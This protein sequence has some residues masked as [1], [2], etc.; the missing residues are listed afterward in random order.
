M[1]AL[2]KSIVNDVDRGAGFAILG[3]EPKGPDTHLIGEAVIS[4]EPTIFFESIADLCIK[5]SVK[6]VVLDLHKSAEGHH[7]VRFLDLCCGNGIKVVAVDCLV[8]YQQYLAHI[9]LPSIFFD[10]NDVSVGPRVCE[11]SL[12]WDHFLLLRSGEAAIWEPGLDVLVLTGG[13]DVNNLGSW[14]PAELDRRLSSRARIKWIR[15]PYSAP[16][17]IPTA[18]RLTWNVCHNPADMNDL[19]STSSYVLTLFGVSFFEVLHHG[20]P[21]VVMPLNVDDNRGEF[22]VIR[23]AEVAVVALDPKDA[24]NKLITLMGS[25]DL[26]KNIS[27]NAKEKMRIDGCNILASKISDLIG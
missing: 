9:W 1:M 16:P 20:I 3:N 27:K 24:V 7:L 11:I 4:N 23:D 15:G 12:G 19:I 25:E 5:N 6:V 10:S 8:N 2:K 14:L 18:P 21:V 13:S 26:A 22:T 17:V